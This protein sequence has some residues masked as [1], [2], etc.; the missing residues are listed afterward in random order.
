MVGS[1]T[2]RITLFVVALLFMA[3]SGQAQ[4]IRGFIS[5]TITDSSN[6]VVPGVQVT[7]TNTGTNITRETRTNELGFYRFVAVE[8]GSYSVEFLA[9]GFENRRVPSVSVSTAQEVVINQTLNVTATTAEVSVI[10]T[11]GTELE[12]T[13]ATIER[14]L[15]D[16][17]VTELPM[18]VYNQGRDIS[19]LALLAPTV[20]RAGG[21]NEMAGNGQRARNN[22]F[23]IDG[24][25]NN[26]L[27]VTISAARTIPEAVQ[28]V[29]VQTTSYSSEFGRSSG[30]QFSAITKSGTNSYHGEVW[31][32]YRGNWLEPISLTDKRAGLKATPRFVLNQFGG[33]AG[34][35]VFKDRTFFFGLLEVALRREAPKAANATS[36]TIPTQAGYAA[37]SNVP[38]GPN[39]T[40]ASRQAVLSALG[41]LP[42]FY[43][44][45]RNFDNLRTASVNGVPIEVGNVVISLPKPYDT[46]YNVGR[47]DHRLTDSGNLSYRYHLDKR[48]QP[49][50]TGNLHFGQR[51][52]ADQLILRQ[53]HAFSYT[54]TISPRFLNEARFGY[55]RASLD[56]P[57]RDPKSAFV[58]IQN[59]FNFGGLNGLP[60]GRLEEL[61]QLQDVATY[62]AGRNSFKF[63]VDLRRSLLS[64]AKFVVNSKG[65]W[66]FTNFQNYLNNDATTVLRAVLQTG[67]EGFSAD[68]WSQAYFFQD[69]VKVTRDFTLNLGLRYEYTTTPLGFLGSKDPLVRAVGVPG[70]AKADKNNWAPRVGFAYSPS[71][72]AGVL[73]RLL[74]DGKTS[75]RGGFGMAYDVLFYNLL[76]NAF[77]SYPY[78]T[79]VS[80]SGPQTT[81]LFPVL[82]TDTPRLNPLNTFINVPEDIENP[83][84]NFWSLSL[85]REFGSNYVLE[86]GYTGN[87]SYHQLR[88]SQYNPGILTPAQAA[89]VISTRNPNSVQVQRL[90]PS[91]GSRQVIE[92]GAKGEYH[93]GYLKFDKRLSKGL[94]VG[95]NYTWS[96]NMSDGDEPNNVQDSST[97]PGLTPSSPQI[98]QTFLNF[99]SEWSRSAFDRPHRFV[100]HYVYEIPWFSSSTAAL[101]HVFGGW[102][103]S[104]FT[105]YQSGQ[106][107]TITTGVDTVGTLGLSTFPARPNY[108][109]NGIITK[110][111]VTGDFRT[112]STPRDGTGIVVT[113]LGTNGL[114]LANSN[115]NGGNL[116]R[117]T[118]RGPS[119]EN[120]SFSVMKKI[121]FAESWQLQLRSDFFNLWNHN[122][123]PNPVANM[124]S[125][126][127]GS[128]T[129]TG[130][131]TDARQITLSAKIRF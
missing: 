16:R 13:N 28:E 107:F 89:T 61:Y 3:E 20:N 80:L 111:P 68:E 84:T 39:Q 27:S 113:E 6:A 78:V 106:P 33:D 5:G 108:N 50:A 128:N 123:F 98:P 12:K 118:F 92:S 87:R 127:F 109:P 110:D 93:A 105:E 17:V 48:K 121:S 117:N 53:N 23:M 95:A 88:Q 126:T 45:I 57:E 77:Q 25:D 104:G 19:R 71:A 102:Q 103:V 37:L 35:P 76:L 75:I 114:P 124:N 130:F 47:I 79:N 44:Q 42:E 81:N 11:P 59:F 90:N 1:F 49:D 38:L 120:W 55:N 26:D 40:P 7:I 54:D 82:P 15:S 29:Q 46:Y 51:F 94:L 9:P 43:P 56:F 129:A 24:V 52:S 122:N 10:E 66:T 32:Y 85:Q 8:P 69:D 99:R 112:F 72:P 67:P 60:Q 58:Q 30:I 62:I 101:R 119:F 64:K 14:T 21:S 115:P 96:V 97:A 70:P 100:V 73:A 31:D 2:V 91:W 86:L 4:L 18:Q 22:N 36:I 74:G 125:P 131:W 63:G 65:T 83:T 34:G 116:G 41:F